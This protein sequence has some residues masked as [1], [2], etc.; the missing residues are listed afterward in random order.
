MKEGDKYLSCFFF[1]VDK[2]NIIWV[3]NTQTYPCLMFI[4]TERRLST[5][6]FTERKEN[7]YNIKII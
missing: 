7:F 5:Q 3:L 1:M 6:L 2:K 4:L